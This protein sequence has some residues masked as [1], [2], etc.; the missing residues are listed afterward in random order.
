LTTLLKVSPEGS[1]D[2][3]K[4]KDLEG[5]DFGFYFPDRIADP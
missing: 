2:V 1:S 3:V 4:Q 5:M